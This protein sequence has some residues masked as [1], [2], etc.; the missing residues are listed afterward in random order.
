MD[1]ENKFIDITN[2]IYQETFDQTYDALVEEYKNGE[3]DFE[4]LEMNLEEQQ[5][6]LMNGLYE[7][8]TKFSYTSGLVDAHQF[9]LT[10]IRKGKLVLE[11]N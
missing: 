6:V 4:T 11:T 8:E 5:K 3:I 7:G 10:M 1:L 2:D 9:V